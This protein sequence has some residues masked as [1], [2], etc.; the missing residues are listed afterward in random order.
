MSI[1]CVLFLQR[2]ILK[3]IDMPRQKPRMRHRWNLLTELLKMMMW[4]IARCFSVRDKHGLGSNV[5]WLPTTWLLIFWLNVANKKALFT[6]PASPWIETSCLKEIIF[7]GYKLLYPNP[8]CYTG[9]C[10]LLIRQKIN[11]KLALNTS[12]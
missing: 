8:G 11:K 1:F 12:I 7:H 4:L 9:K 5:I 3:I 10:C 2:K 6:K